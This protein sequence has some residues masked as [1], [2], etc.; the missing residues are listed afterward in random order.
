MTEITPVPWRVG[1]YA[2]DDDDSWFYHHTI[3]GANGDF[4]CHTSFSAVWAGNADNAKANARLIAAAPDLLAAL[5]EVVRTCEA[6]G[7]IYRWKDLGVD[8]TEARAAIAKAR[9]E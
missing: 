2:L 1:A 9:G 3:Y 6:D 7:M 8:L 4:V 5:E